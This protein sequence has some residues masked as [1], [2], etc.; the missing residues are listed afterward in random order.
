MKPAPDFLRLVNTPHD[1]LP[2]AI[3][4]EHP[5]LALVDAD[6]V[7]ATNV[8]AE[9]PSYT[10]RVLPPDEWP[11]AY[12][13]LED[14]FHLSR[15]KL[16]ASL[17]PPQLAQLMVAETGEEGAREVVAAGF[18]TMIPHFAPFVS[19]KG[20]EDVFLHMNSLL[21]T[22]LPPGAVY[23]ILVQQPREAVEELATAAGLQILDAT[24]CIGVAKGEGG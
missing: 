23:Y 8:A 20:H 2:S 15:E 17:P 11:L 6:I 19:R 12:P 7:E 3:Y 9:T 10:F 18:L 1:P 22:Q 5:S 21:Q 24:A 4:P 14:S 16:V 13:I